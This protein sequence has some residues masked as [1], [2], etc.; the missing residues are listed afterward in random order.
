MKRD[1]LPVVSHEPAPVDDVHNT[2]DEK[3]IPE[4]EVEDKEEEVHISYEDPH[5]TEPEESEEEQEREDNED[6]NERPEPQIVQNENESLN[7]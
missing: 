2:E 4:N 3:I 6:I 7:T 5:N 1:D